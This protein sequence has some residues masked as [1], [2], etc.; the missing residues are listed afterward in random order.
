MAQDTTVQEKT[1][2]KDQEVNQSKKE[3]DPSFVES[4]DNSSGLDSKE[5]ATD[6]THEDDSTSKESQPT[7][8]VSGFTSSSPEDNEYNQKLLEKI[9]A[10]SKEAYDDLIHFEQRNN[11]NIN[12]TTIL[13]TKK[14]KCLL[15]SDHENLNFLFEYIV[16]LKKRKKITASK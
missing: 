1:F 3:S 10:R 12:A 16:Y 8:T 15:E 6:P 2:Q 5:P 9:E 7:D 4:M 14:R 11:Y 13:Q